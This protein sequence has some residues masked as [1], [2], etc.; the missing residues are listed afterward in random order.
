MVNK[1]AANLFNSMR[2]MNVDGAN[3]SVHADADA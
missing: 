1:L 2:G 3:D